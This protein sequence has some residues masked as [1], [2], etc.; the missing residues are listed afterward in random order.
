MTKG[1]VATY[2]VNSRYDFLRAYKILF[3]QL[4]LRQYRQQNI[5]IWR[6]QQGIFDKPLRAI[7]IPFFQKTLNN[8]HRCLHIA[9]I[10]IQHLAEGVIGQLA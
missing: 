1:R 2:F 4:D 8:R 3:R 9:R 6:A 10:N 5:V 7:H